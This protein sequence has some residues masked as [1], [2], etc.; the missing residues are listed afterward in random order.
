MKNFIINSSICFG[1]MKRFRY[2]ID[3]ME[4]GSSGDNTSGKI[5]NKL[6]T[7]CSSEGKIEQKRIVVVK[8][9]A[10]NKRWL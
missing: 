7:I 3:M 6:K 2:G 8:F 1:P 10:Y 5:K 4:L 9:R